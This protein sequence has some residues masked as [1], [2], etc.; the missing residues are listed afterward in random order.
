MVIPWRVFILHIFGETN[1]FG[2]S[3]VAD[4]LDDLFVSELTKTMKTSL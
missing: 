4:E 2:P 1:D 3:K